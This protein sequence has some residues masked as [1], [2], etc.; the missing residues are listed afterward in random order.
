LEHTQPTRDELRPYYRDDRRPY[1]SEFAWAYDLLQPEPIVPRV[2]FMDAT[3]RERGVSPGATVLD[4]GCGTGRYATELAKRGFKVHAVDRSPHLVAVAR[5]RNS[6][7]QAHAS[8]VTF[9]VADLLDVAFSTKYDVVLC[10]GVLN[11]FY[12]DIERRTIFTQFERWLRPGGVLIF[13]VRNWSAS[14]SRYQ[15]DAVHERRVTL[16]DGELRFRSETSVNP[17]AFGLR[18]QESFDFQAAGERKRVESAFVMRCWS[19][20]EITGYMGASFD[21]VSFHSAY[22]EGAW[23][24]RLVVLA[25]RRQG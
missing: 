11:D 25:R 9:D 15:C 4:A 20:E 2:D 12:R 13:D 24:D 7:N 10:H 17:G 23:S 5:R 14:L 22:G 8:R 18:V 19:R 21:D 6:E 1:Y 16:P 3:L